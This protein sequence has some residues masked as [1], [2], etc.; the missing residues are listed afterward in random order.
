[1]KRNVTSIN[2]KVARKKYIGDFM[3]LLRVIVIIMSRFP[4]TVTI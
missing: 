3:V 2:E 1:M 4:T